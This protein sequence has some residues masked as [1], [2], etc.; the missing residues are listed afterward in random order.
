M[1]PPRCARG[2]PERH[3]LNRAGSV[4]NGVMSVQEV[5]YQKKDRIWL[6]LK[7]SDDLLSFISISWGQ[8]SA[9]GRHSGLHQ[10]HGDVRQDV[11][12]RTSSMDT[13][14]TTNRTVATRNKPWIHHWWTAGF[15]FYQLYFFS[16]NWSNVVK[17]IIPDCKNDWLV[18]RESGNDPQYYHDAHP[19]PPFPTFSAP[20]R[21]RK[22]GPK[23]RSCHETE[24]FGVAE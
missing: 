3:F 8:S 17:P 21:W 5:P 6:P 19:I 9:R 15:R 1:S 18:R 20:L 13:L 4:C 7:L 12:R 23:L 14:C 11:P 24:P 2:A 10:L 22:T 16:A